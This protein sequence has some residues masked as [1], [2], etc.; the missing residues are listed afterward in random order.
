M[1]LSKTFVAV[2]SV[3]L[4]I[5]APSAFAQRRG[6]GGQRGEANGGGRAASP[7]S[8]SPRSAAAPRAGAPRAVASRVDNSARAVPRSYSYGAPRAYAAGRR[9]GWTT[10][11]RMAPRTIGPRVV[12]VAPL[13]FYRPYYAFRPR[14]SLGFGL[15]VGFP[16]SY[17]YY[18]GYHDPYYSAYGYGYRYPAYGY[19]SPPT[20]YPAYGYPSPSMGYPAYGYPSPSMGYPVYGYASPS[21]GYPAYAPPQSAYPAPPPGSVQV[22]PGQ[23]QAD[24]G[25][26]SFEITPSTAEVFVDGSYVGTTGEFTPQTQPLGLTPGR[27]RIEIR[28]PGYR[29]M[30]FDVDTVAGQVLPY[31]GALQR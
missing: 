12:R 23:G 17:P 14:V 10:A 16:I 28:A 30:N 26:V 6:G 25:G 21:T 4:L 11:G 31:Q 7:R 20:G 15:W 24:M 29:T 5:G 9:G 1:T 22:Q 8:S 3:A 2:V 18:Y 19:P 13:R 27:H